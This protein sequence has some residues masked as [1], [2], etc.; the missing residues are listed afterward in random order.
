MYEVY[1][2]KGVASM[3]DRYK[4]INHACCNNPRLQLIDEKS[5][6]YDVFIACLRCN[7]H[8]GFDQKEEE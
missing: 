5:M 2:R 3:T 6:G 7:K 8:Q 1:Y 4:M